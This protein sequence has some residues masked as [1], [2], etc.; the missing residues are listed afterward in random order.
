MRHLAAATHRLSLGRCLQSQHCGLLFGRQRLQVPLE[1]LCGVLR[2]EHSLNAF[3]DRRTIR[4]T[5]AHRHARSNLY[6]F[7]LHLHDLLFIDGHFKQV[8][9]T[10]TATV[11][12]DKQ[13]PQGNARIPH[14]QTTTPILQKTLAAIV[15]VTL[16]LALYFG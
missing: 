16:P 4:S 1:K 14:T 13:P 2:T 3:R 9:G 6:Q 5:P 10:I 7:C 11:F 15:Q 12:N 8:P